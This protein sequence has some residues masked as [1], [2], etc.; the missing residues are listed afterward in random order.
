M[1]RI[2][3]SAHR[4]CDGITRRDFLQIG[5]FGAGLTLADM[6][7]LRQVAAASAKQS[8]RSYKAA[9][10]IYLPG[11]P[12]HMDMYDLKPNAPVEYRGE[13]RPIATNV[14]GVQICEHF[15]LQ[16]KMWDKLAA[17]RSI[18][19]VDEH[20]DSLVMTGYPE[21]V[22]MTANHPSV[23]A[24]ISKLRSNTSTNVP[25][26]VSLRGMSRGTEPGYL[27]IAHRPFTPSGP[28]N[29]NLRLANGVTLERLQDRRTLLTSFD[30]LRRDIDASGT[31]SG[32]DSY[33]EKAIEMVVS[34]VVRDALDLS[35]EDPKVRERYKGVEQFLTARRL[36][37]AGVGC[38]T[39]SIGGWD[40]H[41]KNFETLKR[42]LPKVDLGI[43]NL[44]QDLHDRGLDQDV[45]TI[46]WGEFGRTPRINKDAGR[47]HWAPV[48]SALI[49]GGGLKMGQMV[50][51][52]TEKGER[53]K[54][55]PCTVQQVLATVYLALGI[56][57]AMTF[58]NGSGRPVHLLDDR[59][60][61]RELLG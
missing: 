12:S 44:I 8:P 10:M 56:D 25:P 41:G 43:A 3:G 47:D 38:V 23:G 29:A 42:Q 13:F 52:S 21:R 40:T 48:M 58:P 9:I 49:A 35:K 39:L 28:G 30:T 19:S 17:I 20:S 33:T 4:F 27:G 22:N 26:F 15:P 46:M 53:P 6:L 31:M 55:R 51:S 45:V 11:G 54:D 57:P 5:A 37:E 34:G 32:M 14:P 16:A 60:P 18:V 61:I 36:I 2:Y 1:L 7:R 50:G 24:V 59:E